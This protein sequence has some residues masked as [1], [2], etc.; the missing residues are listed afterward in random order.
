MN[1][2]ILHEENIEE[3]AYKTGRTEG[4]L[5]DMLRQATNTGSSWIL[6]KEFGTWFAVR[7]N[8]ELPIDDVMEQ[9]FAGYAPYS[10]GWKL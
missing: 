5:Q 4:T 2:R 10:T 9:L 3:L 8:N 1:Y 7:I 6:W